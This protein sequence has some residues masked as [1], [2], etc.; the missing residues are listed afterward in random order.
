MVYEAF[1]SYNISCDTLEKFPSNLD[2]QVRKK[3]T[4]PNVSNW[5]HLSQLLFGRYEV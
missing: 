3:V 4:P 5:P 2:I 1:F